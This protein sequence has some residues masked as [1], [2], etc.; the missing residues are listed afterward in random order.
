MTSS[1]QAPGGAPAT[2]PAAGDAGQDDLIDLRGVARRYTVGDGRVTALEEVDLRVGGGEFVVVLGPSGS[3][4]TTL[5]NRIRAL[6]VA[7]EGR[8]A[9]AGHDISRA[10]R[11]VKLSAAPGGSMRIWTSACH[12]GSSTITALLAALVG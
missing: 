10:S 8:V 4:K 6:D 12:I 11:R 1:P 9:V 3:G 2:E 7:S 5:L